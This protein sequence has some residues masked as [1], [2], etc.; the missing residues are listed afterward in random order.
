[1]IKTPNIV[2]AL[3][4]AGVA[5]GAWAADAPPELVTRSCANCHGAQGRSIAPTFPQ[6]AAQTAP[7]LE[8][9]LT[10]FRD[11]S[12]ADPHA[13]AYMW[14]MASQ[15]T[16]ANIKALAA[17]Y[18][19]LPPAAGTSQDPAEVAAGKKIYEEGVADANVPACAG[20]HGDKAQGA[21]AIPRLAGQHREYLAAQI[22]AFKNQLRANDI[23]HENV[24]NIT[25]DQIRQVSAFLAAQ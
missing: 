2:L 18:S 17:Y 9:Q 21:D 23:M 8:A 5:G 25:D 12:R 11:R 20:C 10:A 22:L 13:Q 19:S 24:K 1:M 16:D 7:Y 4:M 3:L 15:L 6:L 14:G